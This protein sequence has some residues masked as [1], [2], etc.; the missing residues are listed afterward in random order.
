MAFPPGYLSLLLDFPQQP[1]YDKT[2]EF[3]LSQNPA[4]P[5]PYNQHHEFSIWRKIYENFMLLLRVCVRHFLKRIFSISTTFFW[6][7]ENKKR[8]KIRKLFHSSGKCNKSWN[9]CNNSFCIIFTIFPC[10]LYPKGSIEK[11][12]FCII[13][14]WFPGIFL[15]ISVLY[16]QLCIIPFNSLVQPRVADTEKLI[17]SDSEMAISIKCTINYRIIELVHNNGQRVF[18]YP[19]REKLST[20]Y[21]SASLTRYRG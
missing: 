21:S 6:H 17:T 11:C 9:C 1:Q 2:P 18:L 14:N 8:E 13:S 19:F 10:S 4:H 16:T 15:G 7:W 5:S 3:V 12:Y 20:F